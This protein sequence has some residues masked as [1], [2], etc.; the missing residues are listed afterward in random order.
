MEFNQLL[1]TSPELAEMV[2]EWLNKL[3]NGEYNEELELR[4]K[5]ERWLRERPQKAATHGMVRIVHD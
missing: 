4:R 5:I 2:S 1:I 3:A